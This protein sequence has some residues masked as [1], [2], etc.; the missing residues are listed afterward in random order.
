MFGAS[1]LAELE[2]M[3]SNAID[4]DITHGHGSE[5]TMGTSDTLVF[6]ADG[7]FDLF[8]GVKIDGE[9]IDSSNYTATAGSTV[10]ALTNEYLETLE[11]GVHTIKVVYTVLGETFKTEEA[12]FTV[13]AAQA[14]EDVTDD[15]TDAVTPP[16]AQETSIPTLPIIIA[17]A[18]V[19]AVMVIIILKKKKEDEE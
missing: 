10:V 15:T 3:Y 11:E 8:S 7:H 18:A 4:F 16:A 2:K 9:L 14:A 12:E 19:V 1:R 6:R 17:L 13:K 5:Y